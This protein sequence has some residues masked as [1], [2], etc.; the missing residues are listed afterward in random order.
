L[1]GDDGV[2]HRA[3]P[4]WPAFV[5][6]RLVAVRFRTGRFAG[7]PVIVVADR[8]DPQAFRRLRVRLLQCAHA[9]R[10]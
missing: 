7:R 10:D 3:R 6:A 8:I 1:C 9:D 5:S 2:W 4:G